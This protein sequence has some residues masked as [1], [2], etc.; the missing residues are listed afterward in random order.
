MQPI[1]FRNG[2]IIG[3]VVAVG[4]CGK[5]RLTFLVTT[6]LTRVYVVLRRGTATLAEQDG[7]K[8]LDLTDMF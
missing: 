4:N 1:K 3:F 6:L 5:A 7:F 8:N 2:D